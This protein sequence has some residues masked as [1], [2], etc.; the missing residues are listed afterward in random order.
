MQLAP[1]DADRLPAVDGEPPALEAIALEGLRGVVRAAAVELDSH[2]LPA[3][4]A[5]DL[6][7]VLADGQPDVDLRPRQAA[8]VDEGEEGVLED[9]LRD[10]DRTV[11]ERAADGL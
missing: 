6:V 7:H 10:A 2:L 9:V 8:A 5:I 3:P 11:G 4:Q 1:C